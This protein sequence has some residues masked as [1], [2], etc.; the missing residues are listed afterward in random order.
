MCRR[1][2]STALENIIFKETTAIGLR[3]RDEPRRILP[4]QSVEVT[5]P[6]GTLAAKKVSLPEGERI[7]P[8]YEECRKLAERTGQPIAAI[9]QA[10]AKMTDGGGQ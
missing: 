1:Q 3:Y 5:T 2:S 7:Y 9:Y 4:R 6:W 8:E 10:V